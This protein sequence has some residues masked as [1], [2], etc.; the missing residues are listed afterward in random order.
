MFHRICAGS[1]SRVL[2]GPLS[3]SFLLLQR[4]RYT[5][6]YQVDSKLQTLEEDFISKTQNDGISFKVKSM[7]HWRKALVVSC[8]TFFKKIISF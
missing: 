6:A 8:L 3:V 4:Y 1:V 5:E 2:N 7:S